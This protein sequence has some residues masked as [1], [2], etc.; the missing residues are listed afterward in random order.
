MSPS[1]FLSVTAIVTI[2]LALASLIWCRAIAQ[3]TPIRQ[4]QLRPMY[5]RF[6][7]IAV[8]LSALAS[9]FGEVLSILA[10]AFGFNWLSNLFNLF[11]KGTVASYIYLTLFWSAPLFA[12]YLGII[13]VAVLL[14]LSL[15]QI[16]L[17]RP[18]HFRASF[19]FLTANWVP[20]AAILF[21]A[22]LF[23][24]LTETI[25]FYTGTKLLDLF[26][27]NDFRN[28]VLLGLFALTLSKYLKLFYL[29]SLLT[30]IS[31]SWR[32]I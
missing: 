20:V 16:A 3:Q 23:L 28:S 26:P 12:K 15:P 31:I 5:L 27:Q 1:A 10:Q 4:T 30:Q 32:Q 6:L 7:L 22:S 25:F 24:A 11:S 8:G 9:V 13:L 18:S 14:G 2:A 17:G 29:L 21:I 19:R